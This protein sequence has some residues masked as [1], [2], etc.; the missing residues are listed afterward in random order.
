MAV[1]IPIVSEFNS[2]GIDKAIK[3]FNSLESVGAKA[4]FALKKAAL[5]AAAAVA[6]L[7]VALGDATKAAIEDAASQAELSRQLWCYRCTGG[8]C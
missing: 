4:N 6:G 1:Y 7:A 2:K 5:P 3:E 8:W